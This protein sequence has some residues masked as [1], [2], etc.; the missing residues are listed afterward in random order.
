M[1]TYHN[2]YTHNNLVR[3]ATGRPPT[4]LFAFVPLFLAL[5]YALV[6]FFVLAPT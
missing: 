1:V 5:F 6:F 4:D 3:L 2:F